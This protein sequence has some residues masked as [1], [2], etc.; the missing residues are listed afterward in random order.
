MSKKEN[1]QAIFDEI[2]SKFDELFLNYICLNL[3]YLD[4]IA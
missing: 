4:F 1:A 3:K 2:N